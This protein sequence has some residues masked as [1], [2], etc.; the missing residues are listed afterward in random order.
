ME[1]VRPHLD[2]DTLERFEQHL[3]HRMPDGYRRFMIE[4]NGG[5]PHEES[6]RFPLGVIN[7]F[8]GLGVS[9]TRDL[10][11]A[12]S[13]I[14]VLPSRDLLYIGYADCGELLLCLAGERR[15]QVWLQDP[16]ARPYD[17]NP[18]VLWHDRR[19]MR[20]LADSFEEF[21]RTLKPLSAP[22]SA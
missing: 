21:V 10:A 9:E 15:G 8:F 13:G 7:T 18:R 19:D 12:N 22:Q 3:G 16:E 20:K 6:C 11:E 14:P 1:Y 5:R 4:M 2:A 17:A